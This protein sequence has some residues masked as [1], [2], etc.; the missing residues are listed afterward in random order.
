MGT[1]C[2]AGGGPDNLTEGLPDPRG[3]LGTSVSVSGKPS[4]RTN[5]TGIYNLPYALCH[6]WPPKAL[7]KKLLHAVDPGVTGELRRTVQLQN[8]GPHYVRNK[9]F[10]CRPRFGIRMLLLGLQDPLLDVPHGRADEAD[11]WKDGI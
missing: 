1:G 11:C 2:E 3:K 7:L 5:G 10:S 9:K 4:S 6:P 8:L